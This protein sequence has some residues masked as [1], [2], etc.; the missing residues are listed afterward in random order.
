[1]VGYSAFQSN[2]M[3]LNAAQVIAGSAINR[4]PSNKTL[5]GKGKKP[6]YHSWNLHYENELLKKEAREAKE[7]KQALEALEKG[8]QELET[9]L[10]ITESKKKPSKK[11]IST[12]EQDIIV[13]NE[14]IQKEMLIYAELQNKIVI[15]RRNILA[16]IMMMAAPLSPIKLT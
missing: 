9:K 6:A 3:Q 8:K 12:I 5:L 14:L 4:A 10:V 16:L 7:R 15:R 2:M 13:I 11:A 1:M